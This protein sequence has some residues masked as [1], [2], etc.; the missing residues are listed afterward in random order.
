MPI[1]VPILN[2]SGHI[3]IIL[4]AGIADAADNCQF[5]NNTAQTDS[6][7]D[8]IGDVCD[9]TKGTNIQEFQSTHFTQKSYY[10]KPW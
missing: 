6:D 7:N 1:I 4:N 3:F 2:S 10:I 9:F 5:T 8:G